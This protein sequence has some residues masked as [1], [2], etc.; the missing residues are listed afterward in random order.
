MF[1]GIRFIMRLRTQTKK[2]IHRTL[3]SAGLPSMAIVLNLMC[4]V[5][6]ISEK[7]RDIETLLVQWWATVY[8]AGLALKKKHCFKGSCGAIYCF[9]LFPIIV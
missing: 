9:V 5:G 1:P 6:G 3:V 2:K 4:Y 7:I 8:D